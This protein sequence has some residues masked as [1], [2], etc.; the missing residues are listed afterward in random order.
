MPWAIS[1]TAVA[2]SCLSTSG[3]STVES[4]P[5]LYIVNARRSASLKYSPITLSEN[6]HVPLMF[7]SL[8]SILPIEMT[9]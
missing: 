4:S 9:S 2:S 8:L 7:L 1:W 5:C 6:C 3:K